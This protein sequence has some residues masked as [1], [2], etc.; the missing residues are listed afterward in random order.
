[1]IYACRWVKSMNVNSLNE[2]VVSAKE[3]VNYFFSRMVLA[4]MIT[5]LKLVVIVVIGFVFSHVFVIGLLLLYTIYLFYDVISKINYYFDIIKDINET[6][7]ITE[8]EASVNFKEV[9]NFVFS[10]VIK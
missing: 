1:M 9:H 4:V 3:N 6:L 7:G 8:R 2:Q 10:G 5:L